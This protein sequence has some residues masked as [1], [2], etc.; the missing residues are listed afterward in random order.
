MHG[1]ADGPLV[2]AVHGMG[3]TRGTWRFLVPL[4]VEQG[5]RVATLDVR[6]HGASSTGW[7]SYTPRAVGDD[8]IALIRHLGGGPAVVIGNSSG[9]ASAI[10]AAAEAPDL[11]SAIVLEATFIAPMQMSPLLRLVSWPVL[12]SATLFAKVFHPSLYKAG[13][14][15][16]LAEYTT[17]LRRTLAE[18]GR[19]AAVRGVMGDKEECHDRIPELRCPVLVVMGTADS[20]YPDARAEARTAE[21]VI[22]AHTRT[23]VLL[24]DGAGH[25]PHAEVPAATAE[26]V[27]AFLS[28]V[29]RA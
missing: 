9:T 8:V 5:L 6:G 15:A 7:P 20:D 11:V 14:P 16:D 26:G 12:R 17:A 3:D 13:K 23:D 21:R 27:A 1:P 22:G 25:Y 19:M 4:L 18:P 28:G 2:V 10:W 29:T 24:L